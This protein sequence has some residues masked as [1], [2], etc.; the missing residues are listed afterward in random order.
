VRRPAEVRAAT[1][2]GPVVKD[3]RGPIQTP[4]LARG[5]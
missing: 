1:R 5:R 2:K 4:T 3:A